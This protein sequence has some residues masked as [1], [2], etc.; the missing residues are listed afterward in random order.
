MFSGKS[1]RIFYFC[2]W[3]P[4]YKFYCK[5]I[6]IVGYTDKYYNLYKEYYNKGP[7]IE[8]NEFEKDEETFVKQYIALTQGMSNV[9]IIIEKEEMK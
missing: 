2:K 4:K 3:G 6:E 9:N 8:V 5:R 1:K 7:V